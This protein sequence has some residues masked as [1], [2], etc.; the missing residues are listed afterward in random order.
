[1][2]INPES[3]QWRESYKLLVGSILPRP[4]ALSYQA[5]T[6]TEMTISR[7]SVSLLQFALTL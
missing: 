3:L 5:G 6:K 7:L 1:M 4:I 2:E